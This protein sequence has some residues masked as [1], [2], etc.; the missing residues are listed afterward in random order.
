MNLIAT[1]VARPAGS[2]EGN[3]QGCVRQMGRSET[4]R[5]GVTR[6]AGRCVG[7]LLD[8][9]AGRS[10]AEGWCRYS[11]VAGDAIEVLSHSDVGRWLI[12]DGGLSGR[13]DEA[14]EVLVEE[15]IVLGA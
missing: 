13:L 2:P 14:V 1:A 9:G 15:A 6:D 8:D 3:L 10:S 11:G 4:T 7:A 5:T 12:R